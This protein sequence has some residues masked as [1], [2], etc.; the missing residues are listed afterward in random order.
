MR[1]TPLTRDECE[2]YLRAFGFGDQFDAGTL[3][4]T[5]CACGA[6]VCRGWKLTAGPTIE[7]A[8]RD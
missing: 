3:V 6:P 8:P 7:S 5:A 4:L 1:P 2:T